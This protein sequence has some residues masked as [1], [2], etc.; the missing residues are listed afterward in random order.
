M[1][2]AV[3]LAIVLA[4]FALGA[5]LWRV[6]RVLAVTTIDVSV[7]AR[8]TKRDRARISAWPR[9]LEGTAMD[10]LASALA[11]PDGPTR[12]GAVNVALADLEGELGWGDEVT[13]GLLRVLLFGTFFASLVPLLIGPS[14][15]PLID[16]LVLL[17]IGGGAAIGVLAARRLIDEHVRETRLAIDAWVDASVGAH[18]RRGGSKA[19]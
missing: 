7:I 6:R 3:L 14:S 13:T 2:L 11:L 5:A 1:V 12:N 4:V 18:A 15:G 16:G 10:E 9:L 19:R 17:S 8:A